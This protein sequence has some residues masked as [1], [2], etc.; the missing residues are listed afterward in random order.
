ML[1]HPREKD[2]EAW[3][4]AV[5]GVSKSWARLNKKNETLKGRKTF[6]IRHDEWQEEKRGEQ[7]IRTDINCRKNQT[8]CLSISLSVLCQNELPSVLI[9]TG[10][11]Y[12]RHDIIFSAQV[13]TPLSLSTPGNHSRIQKC[14]QV[15]VWTKMCQLRAGGSA[16]LR[17]FAAY[18]QHAA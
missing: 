10:W 13:L 15:L 14:S 5:H 7:L 17:F 8:S 2:Q 18:I 1:R 11:S 9:M 16:A 3:R 12:L 4:D 6:K